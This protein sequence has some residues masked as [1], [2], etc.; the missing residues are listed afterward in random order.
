ME[1]KDYGFLTEDIAKV[2]FLQQAIQEFIDGGVADIDPFNPT[3]SEGEV[4]IEYFQHF[5][6]LMQ[7]QPIL[8][9]RLKLMKDKDLDGL[10]D[11]ILLVCDLLGRDPTESVLEFHSNMS[12][13]CLD[14][15]SDLT[16][17]DMTNYEGLD[18]GFH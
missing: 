5:H 6:A 2:E 18:V 3:P 9:T 7:Y 8:Y 14:A 12:V 10:V 1:N 15:L 16:G 11:A 17:T 13:E 4:L